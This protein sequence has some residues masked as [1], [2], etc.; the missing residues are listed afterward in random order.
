M[1]SA[2]TVWSDFDKDPVHAHSWIGDVLAVTAAMLNG[3]AD[4]LSEYCIKNVDRYEL[5]GMLGIYGTI[6]TA[7][8]C[9]W[10]EGEVLLNVV[11]NHSRQERMDIALVIGWYVI[12]VLLY[13][14]GEAFFLVSSEATLL[15]LSLQ[16][17]NLWAIVFSLL[18]FHILPP[19]LFYTALVL[20]VGGVCIYE[21]TSQSVEKEKIYCDEKTETTSLQSSSSYDGYSSV[22]LF[23]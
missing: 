16:T 14:M 9:P 19:V 11:Q 15:N 4:V 8:S 10:I 21:A 17:S 3:S 5:L 6:L 1:G 2:M 22:P 7:V 23:R 18:F 13:Y 12:S 20:V